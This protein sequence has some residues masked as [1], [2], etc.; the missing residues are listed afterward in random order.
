M[1]IQR[2]TRRQ[3]H[4]LGCFQKAKNLMNVLSIKSD[5]KDIRPF[6]TQHLKLP[7][8]VKLNGRLA[9]DLRFEINAGNFPKCKHILRVR[10]DSSSAIAVNRINGKL[11]LLGD[12][13]VRFNLI[14]NEPHNV[15]GLVGGVCHWKFVNLPVL[16][17][18]NV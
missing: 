16:V 17:K 4:I 6:V 15:A 13:H 18:G 5:F 7:L 11:S 14:A 8:S 9:K 12:K 3:C 10:Q 1:H 2:I